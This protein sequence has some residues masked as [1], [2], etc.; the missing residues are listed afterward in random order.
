M[1]RLKEIK[2]YVNKRLA[3]MKDSDDM[4]KAEFIYSK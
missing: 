3:D 1:G 2:K 4:L